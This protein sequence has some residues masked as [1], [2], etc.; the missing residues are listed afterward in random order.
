MEI[1]NFATQVAAVCLV[2]LMI[3]FVIGMIVDKTIGEE[4]DDE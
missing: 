2:S 4:E 1:F 3:G